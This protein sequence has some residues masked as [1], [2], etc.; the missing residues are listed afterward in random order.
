MHYTSISGNV[1]PATQTVRTPAESLAQASGNCIDGTFVYAAALEA[2]GFR[3]GVAFVPDHAF[4]AYADAE[5]PAWS[6][7]HYLETTMTGGAASYLDANLSGLSQ[8]QLHDE[9]GDLYVVDV[10]A[11]RAVGVYPIPE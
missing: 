4:L 1:F 3:A 7:C 9:T 6:K 5:D 10:Q 2:L 8:A 11:M